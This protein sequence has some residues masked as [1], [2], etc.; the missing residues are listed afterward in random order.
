MWHISVYMWDI[1][2]SSFAYMCSLVCIFV[3]CIYV[4]MIYE[5]IVAV[6]CVLE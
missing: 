4:A 5:V 3:C 6:G 2:M 1:F